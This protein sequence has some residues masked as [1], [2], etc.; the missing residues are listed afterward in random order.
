MLWYPIFSIRSGFMIHLADRARTVFLLLVSAA[1]LFLPSCAAAGPESGFPGSDRAALIASSDASFRIRFPAAYPGGEDVVCSGV[2]SGDSIVLTAERPERIAGAAFAL[3][4]AGEPDESGARPFSVS[5]SGPDFPGAMPVDPAAAR[6]LSVVFSLLY[7]PEGQRAGGTDPESGA[8]SAE[9]AVFLFI[10]AVERRGEE[11]A[12]L[13]GDGVL[14]LSPDGLPAR[15]ECPDLS[16]RSR[17]V[18][19]EAYTLS[20]P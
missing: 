12:F 11:T 9:E 8:H 3:T 13:Y 2:R 10:P 15:A 17:T 1:V 5:L 18:V 14:I 19:F 7:D 4:M 6:G 16:G 20:S